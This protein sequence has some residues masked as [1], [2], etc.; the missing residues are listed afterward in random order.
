MGQTI[1]RTLIASAPIFALLLSACGVKNLPRAQGA[2]SP[3]AAVVEPQR[4]DDADILGLDD[5]DVVDPLSGPRITA[6][7][8]D[9]DDQVT[10]AEVSRTR[11]AT[12]KSF[13]LD[14]LLN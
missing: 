13:I 6:T 9:D 2:D 12:N 4:A 3:P 10:A 7:G 1:R 14:P 8:Q 5:A 11:G